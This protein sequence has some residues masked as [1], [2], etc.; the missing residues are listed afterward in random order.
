MTRAYI[1]LGALIAILIVALMSIYIVDE[2]QKALVL[3]FGQ[4]RTVKEDPGLSFK[5]PFLQNVV[6]YDDRIQSLDTAPQEVTPL[7]DRR[8]VVDAF[9]RWRISDVV[10]FRQAVGAGGIARAENR[11]ETI[12][13]SQIREVLGS[14]TSN[15]ILSAD[16]V[17]LMNR[18][19]DGA[20]TRARALGVQVIDVRIKRT[21]LPNQNLEA[22]FQR[23]TAERARE[24]ADERARGQEAA[25]RVRAQADRTATE[26]VS[27]AERDSEIIRGEAD[28]QRNAIFAEAFGRDPEFFA[29]YR[30]LR[31]YEESL[32]GGNSSL[33][34]TPNSEFFD[35]LKSDELPVAN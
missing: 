21:E 17:G 22:T 4:I 31:A 10:Q 7:D 24:A 11:L 19:R 34:I 32:Q 15:S 6:Y 29:F 28:A 27:E 20:I 13:T 23:M 14:V 9:A 33:V 3:Q 1:A 5:I 26:L 25:Q 2:R 35:Y 8:L 18:I 12:L 30:S 16:R